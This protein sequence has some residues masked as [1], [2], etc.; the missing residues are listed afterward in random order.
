M[1]LQHNQFT[2]RPL[3]LEPSEGAA[4][5]I[6]Y[7]GETEN[8]EEL[9]QLERALAKLNISTHRMV[10]NR[11]STSKE[12]LAKAEALFRSVDGRGKLVM[13]CYSGH[14]KNA[15]GKLLAVR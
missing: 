2:L 7:E 6:C 11:K 14:G 5:T 10:L 13:V 12:S 1:S 15:S 8:E 3:Y 4:I 9:A